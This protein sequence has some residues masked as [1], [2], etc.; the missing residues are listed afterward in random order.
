MTLDIFDDYDRVIDHDAD[1]ENEAEQG[2]IIDRKIERRHHSKSANQRYRDRQDRND[3]G[4]PALQEY[5]DDNDDQ[6]HRLIDRLDQLVNGLRDELGRIVA[7]IVV[8]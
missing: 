8:K 5:Q 2:Q 1:R 3:S 4:T 7:D 6:Q